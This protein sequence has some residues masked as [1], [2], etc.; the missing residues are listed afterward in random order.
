MGFWSGIWEGV[1]KFGGVV[2]RVAKA[3]WD[4]ANGPSA[5]SAYE[6]LE[7]TI[8]RHETARRRELA[9]P[10]SP[11]FLARTTSTATASRLREH[12]EKIEVISTEL[13]YVKKFMAIQNE[14]SRLRS[15]AELID[16]GMANI[17]IHASSLSVHY[18]TM[19][20]I[21]GL[22]NDVNT[23]RNGIKQIMRTFNYNMN[24][25]GANAEES[26]L[27]KIEGVDIE[28]KDG[29]ISLVS[30]FDAFDRTRQLLSEEI[31]NL[32]QLAKSHTKELQ[33]LRKHA[34]ALD[35][36]LG[37]KI[38]KFIDKNIEPTIKAAADGSYILQ[39][40]MSHLPAAC[41]DAQ[42][43]LIFDKGRLKVENETSTEDDE[44]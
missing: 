33:N 29:A 16:R 41:R 31:D 1:K 2:S 32:S 18:K 12:E 17:K 23:L 15:S 43:T 21:N 42:G 7:R 6:E 9:I 28:I 22:T 8:N 30:A 37:R 11:D 36:D 34:S 10:E 38:I 19:R 14:F 39:K 44:Q 20:N 24:V 4:I 27:K 40:E 13:E 26:Q 35:D 25:L 3:A 5:K